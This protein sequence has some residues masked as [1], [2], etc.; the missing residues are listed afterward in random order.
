[1]AV[2]GGPGS[3][4]VAG[5]CAFAALVIAIYQVRPSRAP[6]YC[7]CFASLSTGMQRAV[8]LRFGCKPVAER[9]FSELRPVTPW[10]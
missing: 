4:A 3:A 2:L 1:M 5:I 9:N 7:F 10:C 6:E 8:L